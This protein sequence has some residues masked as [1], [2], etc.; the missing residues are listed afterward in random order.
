M[1]SVLCFP[2][3]T[4]ATTLH[5]G[6]LPHCPPSSP[7]PFGPSSSSSL[8][9]LPLASL[10]WPLTPAGTV[11]SHLACS[12]SPYSPVCSA[13]SCHRSSSGLPSPAHPELV[14]N[15]LPPG[16]YSPQVGQ[17]SLGWISSSPQ[18][19]SQAHSAVNSMPCPMWQHLFLS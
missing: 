8:T 18:L 4:K 2:Q 16:I 17:Q 12:I 3:P 5:D 6:H 1:P 10:N 14:N 7:E 11:L 9:S 13:H 19:L 15:P